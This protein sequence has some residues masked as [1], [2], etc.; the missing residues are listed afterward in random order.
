[1]SVCVF[2]GH[3]DSRHRI[4]DAIREREA[5]GEDLMDVLAQHGWTFEELLRIESEVDTSVGS[6]EQ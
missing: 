3:P 5:A 1:M 2:C 4:V 6:V